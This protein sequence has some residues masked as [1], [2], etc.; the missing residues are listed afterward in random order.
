MWA[1]NL[2]YKCARDRPINKS[3]KLSLGDFCSDDL[4]NLPNFRAVNREL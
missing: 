1:F 3:K 2:Q 4:V